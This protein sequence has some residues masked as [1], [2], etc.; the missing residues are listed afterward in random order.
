MPA[1]G[2]LT[3]EFPFFRKIVAVARALAVP[4]TARL[5]ERKE[6]A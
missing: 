4:A 5:G 1:E 2:T 6:Q 3:P